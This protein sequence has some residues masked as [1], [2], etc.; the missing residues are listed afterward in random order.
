[1][2]GIEEP[3][4]DDT[5]VSTRPLSWFSFKDIPPVFATRMVVRG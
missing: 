4:F 3:T 5:V 2:D 1:M